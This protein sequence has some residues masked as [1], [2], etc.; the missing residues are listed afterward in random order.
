MGSFGS[1]SSSEI[2]DEER[3]LSELKGNTL[4]VY[5]YLLKKRHS[6]AGVRE[7]QRVLGFSSPSSANYQLEKLR[8]LGLVSKDQAGNYQVCQ[9]VKTGVIS[10]FIFLGGH[11]FP[12]YLIYA[13]TTSMMILVFIALSLSS[14]SL[15]TVAALLPGTLATIIF[16]Y[17]TLK[18][19]RNRPS[20]K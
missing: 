10:T 20:S 11:A 17:E 19:W 15:I 4:L 8:K 13:L 16:W 12:K 2:S 14:F 18:V 1:L 9:V 7:V 3:I 6:S 5:W